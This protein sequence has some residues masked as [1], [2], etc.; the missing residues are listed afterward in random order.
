MD[1]T[2]PFRTLGTVYLVGAGFVAL[3]GWALGGGSTVALL[4]AAFLTGTCV[5]GGQMS[6]IA[7]A[8]VLYPTDMRSTGVGWA[9]GIG[10]LGGIAAPLIIGAALSAGIAP[11]EVFFAMAIVLVVAGFCV[12]A[13]ERRVQAVRQP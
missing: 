7:L 1:R 3:L 5:T 12:L 13:L 8:T 2:S 4:V 6:V 11:R 9:L 10:R